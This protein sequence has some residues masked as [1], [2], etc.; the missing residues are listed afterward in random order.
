M[1]VAFRVDASLDIGTG[2]VMR[3][4][5]LAD[6][7]RTRGASCVFIGREH[8]GHMLDM[9][10]QRGFEV[11]ALPATPFDEKPDQQ[12]PPP[13]ASWLGTDWA[14]DAMQTL[15]ALGAE[16]RVDW[17][18]VDHYALDARWERRV[19]GAGCRVLIIDD[20]ADRP[21]D[22]DLLLDQNLGREAAH[23]VDYLPA[24][25]RL[26][27]GPDYALLRSQFAA[28]RPAVWARH[29]DAS[30][31]PLQHLL[32]AMGGV[33]KHNVTGQVLEALIG[34]PWPEN[35][36]ITVVMGSRA[37][38]LAD[39]RAQAERMP[40]PTELK[41]DV[42]D[43]AEWMANSDLAIGAAGTTALERCCMGL[44]TVTLVLA[45]N[46]RSGALAL[47]GAGCVAL[48]D[49]VS[50]LAN[51]VRQ[52]LEPDT[53]ADMEQACFG[54]V[55][56]LGAQRV[57]SRMYGLSGSGQLRRMTHE[58]LERVFAWRNHP[59]TRRAMFNQRKITWDDHC[60]WFDK[61]TS[62]P[63]RRVLLLVENGVPLGF[64]QFSGVAPG[65]PVD[66]GFYTAPDA[67]KGT[68][69]KLGRQAIDH[70]FGELGAH[71]VCGQVLVG[72]QASINFHRRLGF[73]EEGVLREQKRVG[74]RHENLVCFGLLDRE[75]TQAWS[76]NRDE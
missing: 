40:W 12:P 32:V 39:V 16:D 54:M 13:H 72:N 34:G 59:R 37:P 3:C 23:Y 36:R 41:V 15:S 51:A 4:L 45:E 21:H 19:R 65:A 70:A 1:K 43:M 31:R 20:L 27:I 58:D 33:D 57:V 26:L 75:W 8:G 30:V 14:T 7:L 50:G 44:P 2:H 46:Q 64:V 42:S 48:V 10:R 71:K 68:G 67:P 76:A 38:W 35:G 25:C 6:T 73:S 62:D 11:A 61:V 22:G 49:D 28:H 24:A 55:D 74:L 56:G 52:L 53:R 69:L 60:Q 29:G 17:L 47:H 63:S 18:V 9:I 66:W 5:T